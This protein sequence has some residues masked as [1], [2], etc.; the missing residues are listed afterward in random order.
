MKNDVC[1]IFP[2]ALKPAVA[3]VSGTHTVCLSLTSDDQTPL[4]GH[5]QDGAHCS[6]IRVHRKNIRVH[7]ASRCCRCLGRLQEVHHAG[8]YIV[9]Y[10]MHP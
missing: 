5:K 10:K 7:V 3:G 6:D 9:G 2:R 4:F 8:L 1:V